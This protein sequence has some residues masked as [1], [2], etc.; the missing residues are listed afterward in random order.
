MLDHNNIIAMKWQSP[1]IKTPV[2]DWFN[3]VFNFQCRKDCAN[4]EIQLADCM[5]A[6]GYH[7]G[8]EKCRL[9]IEDMYECLFMWKRTRR[10][11]EMHAERYRQKQN[12][13]REEAFDKD[14]CPPLDLF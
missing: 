7:R 4:Y 14:S 11:F 6:Y 1:F 8:K 12:G 2:T 9:I 10:V 13:E 3:Q 5:E